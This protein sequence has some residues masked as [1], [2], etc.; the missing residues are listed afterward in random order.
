MA[1]VGED[2]PGDGLVERLVVVV[3]DQ[4]VQLAARLHPVEPR[5]LGAGPGEIAVEGRHRARGHPERRD[6]P[7]DHL[8]AE[9]RELGRGQERRPPELRHVGEERA[10]DGRGEDAELLGG[11]EGLREDHVRA[12]LLV[13]PCAG[14]R[15][16][17][18]LQLQR[19][20]PGDDPE[21][22]RGPHGGRHLPRHLLGARP[23]ACPRGARTSWAGPGPRA[24][25]PRR[26]RPPARAR[27]ARRSAPPRSPCRRRPGPAAPTRARSRA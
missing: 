7:D 26:P 18:A 25:R 17:E 3:A 19:V 10:R 12:G 6:R 8:V 5:R 1:L 13:E 22:A 23:G 15:A 20:G 9:A 16:V 4:L 27:G 14:D 24:G 21:V 11:P 2:A